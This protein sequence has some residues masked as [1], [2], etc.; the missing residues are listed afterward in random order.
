MSKLL[1]IDGH[2][3]LNRA[4]YGVPDFTNSEGI[5]TNAI[6]GFL[7][8][9]FKLLDVENPDKIAVAFDVHK[10]TFRHEKYEEYKGTRKPMNPDLKQQVPL[11]KDVL[12]SMGISI[13]EMPGF[14]AD[15]ILGT[16]SLMAEEKDMDVTVV[17][18]DRDL[19]QLASKKVKI[20]MPKTS[21]GVTTVED[22]YDEDVV[23]KYK[24]TP[25]QF[26]DVKA[27]MGD[28]SD[29]IKGVAGIGEKT[30]TNLIV[31][32]DSI[33]GIYEHIDELKNGKAKTN[34]IEG[35]EDAFFSKFLVTI[36]R[37]VPIDVDLND[38]NM[39]NMYTQEAYEYMRRFE[40]KS[41]LSRFEFEDNNVSID[42]S[43]SILEDFNEVIDFLD[44][45]VTKA[46]KNGERIAISLLK[47]EG[48]ILGC[49]LTTD[50]ENITVIPVEY[51]ITDDL[52]KDGL[53]KIEIGKSKLVMFD[54]KENIKSIGLSVPENIEDEYV[55]G[56]DDPMIL[57]YLIDP[58][59][60]E[61]SY[62]YIAG[63]SNLL[64]LKSKEELLGKNKVKKALLE[65]REKTLK[66]CAYECYVAYN[67]VDVLKDKLKEMDML[68]LY[69]NIEKPLMLVLLDMEKQGIC[70]K[71]EL[72]KEYS[73]KLEESIVE[74]EKKIYEQA[75]CEFNI[76]SPKQLGVVLFEK[77]GL[78]G[79]KKTK[80]GYSTNASVLEKLREDNRIVDDILEYRSLTKL[81][82]TYAD[83]LTAYIR[84]DG[85]IH[86]RFNQT[87]TATGRISSNDPN[88]QNIPIRMELGREIRKVFVPKE[89]CE[90]VDCD[91][92]QVE[93]RILAH[94]SDDETL[95]ES[96]KEDCDI[97][98]ITAS[99]VFKVPLDEVTADLRRKAKAVNFGIVYGIS[100]FGLGEDIGVSPKEAKKY[101]EE[102]FATYPKIKVFL[103]NLVNQAKEKGYVTTL[104]GRRRPVPEI[105]SGQFMQVKFG[106]RI[107]M[108]SP[109][110]GTAAD[111]MKIAMINVFKELNKRNLKSKI[112]VQVHD[113]LLLECPK[114]E[115]DMVKEIV[116]DKMEN[117]Y[118]LKVALEV[119]IDTGDN[120][121]S[122]H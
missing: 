69:D 33:E 83:G 15:D 103:D 56:F 36:K 4:F 22:Y 82:S 117:A 30:A 50:G 46:N 119:S 112:L 100:S 102:Y 79:G 97:H 91:Y 16:L 29:N 86:G 87:V 3:I 32:Y 85:R 93:L 98:R 5:H 118:L 76:N 25:K 84:G 62:D 20:S 114:D 107:A 94:M 53:K 59:R 40:F 11:I 43:I 75:G 101:I 63:I 116:K 49:A 74:I 27:L 48:E 104:L 21:K 111:I 67:C 65:D 77:M 26:I 110:Q 35:K 121:L 70:V 24:V 13:F 60:S 37:D 55:N 31:S 2:S 41:F 72:L 108:N 73:K 99:K 54:L 17:S 80:T 105:K 52:I 1:I 58:L 42:D 19:L 10:K 14:E 9:L 47:D 23:A 57:G 88:L 51:F 122:A 8:I 12:R 68:K 28:S 61:Y 106:E 78:D 6:Y 66:I 120:W 45:T 44:K 7:N 92:S 89:G 90:F 64:S 18:G 34:L 115:V 109:I 71:A 113:E 39:G 81:K 38:L 96:Y 95:I